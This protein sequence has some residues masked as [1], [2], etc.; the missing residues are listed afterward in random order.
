MKLSRIVTS[1]ALMAGLTFIPIPAAAR[2]GGHGGHSAGG[3][4]GHAG[5]S[6]GSRGGSSVGV[7]RAAPPSG[8]VVRGAAVPHGTVSGR[9]YGGGVYRGYGGVYR[10]YGGG[11]YHGY[12]GG[13]YHGYGGGV[14]HGYG[15]YYSGHHHWY[16]H[17]L[18]APYYRFNPWFG[19]GFGLYVG[20]PVAYPYWAWPDP[21]VYGYG[22]PNP[23]QY[24]NPSPYGSYPYPGSGAPPQ[25]YP[26]DPNV[27]TAA[28]GAGA[29]PQGQAQYGGLSFQVTPATAGVFV[30]QMYA[31]PVSQ[32]SPTTEP[33]TLAPGRHH[34]KIQADGY[35]TIE[36]DVSITPGQVLPYQGTM[37]PQ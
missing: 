18:A 2:G 10:A 6:S 12:G 32:F 26:D 4:S 19:V 1:A 14:Y 8:G 5:S 25:P 24:A 17:V 16:G 36:F 20:Y 23:P 35:R 15:V 7:A 3:H 30:D 22:Y 9:Y 28:P 13:V 31:G 27:V 29:S 11:V 34:I 33:L 21:Y 37:L